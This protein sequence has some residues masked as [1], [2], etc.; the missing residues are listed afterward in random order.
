M[1]GRGVERILDLVEWFAVTPGAVSLS[2]VSTALS[3]PKSSA[4]QMLRT[5]N[6][7]G[8]IERDNTGRY[9]LTRLPGEITAFGNS[10]GA[11][12]ALAAPLIARAVDEVGESGF[13]AVL[14][15][16]E[17]RYLNKILPARE[18]R[19]DRDMSMTRPAH[20]VASGIVILSNAA[21]EVLEGINA[22]LSAKD[23][24]DLQ[25]AI[26]G[27]KRDGFYMNAHGVVEGAAG[28]AAPVFDA[29]GRVVGAINIAGPQG[30][31]AAAAERVSATA[32][33]TA[34]AVTEEIRRR[35]IH[36]H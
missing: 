18:I 1:S 29:E 16:S 13:L 32:L 20:K 34:R 9:L 8:Y 27:A 28:V 36:A 25:A 10:H 5:L 15:G 21:A 31:M 7:R 23:R 12:L 33:S 4:L 35:A 26:K 24:A 17:I 22:R 11:L 2:Q 3:M 19:Y 14:E 30:R 6:E